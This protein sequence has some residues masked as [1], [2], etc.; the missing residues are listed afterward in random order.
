MWYAE[1]QD[2]IKFGLARFM[3]EGPD[4]IVEEPLALMS[5]LRYFETEGLTPDKFIRDR[6]QVNKGVAFEEA[7]LLACTRLFRQGAR[8][9][10]VF[11]FHGETP[12]WARQS[13]SIVTRGNGDT[14]QDFDIPNGDPVVPSNGIAFIADDPEDV[15]KWIKSMHTGWCLPGQNAGPDLM[16]WLRL[17]DGRLLLLLFQA[18][19]YLTGNLDT[20]AAA[21]LAKAIRSLIPNEIF[22]CLQEINDMLEAINKAEDCFTGA[23]YNVLRVVAAYPLDANFG[24]R[25]LEVQ[26]ASLKDNHP[27]ATLDH[28]QLLNS[29]TRCDAM[30]SVLSSLSMSLKR[31]RTK[32]DA[33][34][35]VQH[36]SKSRKRTSRRTSARTSAGTSRGISVGTSRGTSAGTSSRTSSGRSSGRSSRGSWQR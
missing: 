18:K 16:A 29:L 7:V 27:L 34:D 36:I 4:I 25:S 35:E 2:L 3:G 5:V 22:S 23:R 31:V 6:M 28:A 33:Q 10:Q 1:R 24:S 13:A 30:P 9:D 32:G 15:K 20:I 21:V 14:L 8:L 11:R 12:P 26:N 17:S 19:C